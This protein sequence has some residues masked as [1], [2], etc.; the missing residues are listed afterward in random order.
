MTFTWGNLSLNCVSKVTATSR[1]WSSLWHRLFI[2][3]QVW[4]LRIDFLT[5]A[6]LPIS[7]ILCSWVQIRKSSRWLEATKQYGTERERMLN[8]QTIIKHMIIVEKIHSWYFTVSSPL[9][10]YRTGSYFHRSSNISFM[11]KKKKRSKEESLFG[12]DSWKTMRII[13]N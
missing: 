4:A 1:I 11:R 12:R 8:L 7:E 3:K 2:R 5:V 13:L 10:S 6:S 9:H